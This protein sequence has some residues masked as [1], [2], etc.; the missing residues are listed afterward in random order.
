MEEY[1]FATLGSSLLLKGRTFHLPRFLEQYSCNGFYVFPIPSCQPSNRFGTA[2]RDSF[3]HLSNIFTCLL[4]YLHGNVS[5][6]GSHVILPIFCPWISFL[7]LLNIQSLF[8]QAQVTGSMSVRT[9]A[10][11]T[12]CWLFL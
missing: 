12:Q 4:R 8:H 10:E 9:G 11:I 2:S 1:I 7:R 5:P 6:C 3:H